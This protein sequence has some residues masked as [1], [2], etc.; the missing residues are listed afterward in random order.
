ML[1]ARKPDG[2][3]RGGEEE[4]RED[5]LPG[6]E[7]SLRIVR[8]QLAEGA[9]IE[10]FREGGGHYTEYEIRELK[11]KSGVFEELLNQPKVVERI[12]RMGRAEIVRF[13][14]SAM[15]E[16]VPSEAGDNEIVEALRKFMRDRNCDVWLI[17]FDKSMYD[18]AAGFGLRPSRFSASGEE[19]RRRTGARRRLRSRC[20]GRGF[21][22]SWRS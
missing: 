17:T 1:E 15:P 13:R 22:G 7:T 18:I 5:D 20:A 21:G 9:R 10:L 16:E 3:F 11:L 6:V 14:N 19:S 12:F 8:H 4:A 2:G